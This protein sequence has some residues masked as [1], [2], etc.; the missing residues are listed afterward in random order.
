MTALLDP[1]H[2]LDPDDTP[3]DDQPRCSGCGWDD[4]DELQ[5]GLNGDPYCGDCRTT[6]AGQDDCLGGFTFAYAR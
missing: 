2:Q 3:D 4:P 6:L 1:P 5:P